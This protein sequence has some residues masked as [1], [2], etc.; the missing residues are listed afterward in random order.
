MPPEEPEP[1]VPSRPPNKFSE[2]LLLNP[3]PT[4]AD[5][6]DT[7][8]PCNEPVDGIGAAKEEER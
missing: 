4:L 6:D 5:K 2:A 3:P 7:D 8:I 1:M